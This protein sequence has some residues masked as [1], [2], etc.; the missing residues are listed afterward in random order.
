MWP[1]LAGK[2]ISGRSRKGFS[3]QIEGQREEVYVFQVPPYRVPGLLSTLQ[4][5]FDFLTQFRVMREEA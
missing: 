5:S 1:L 2:V 3:S 4:V